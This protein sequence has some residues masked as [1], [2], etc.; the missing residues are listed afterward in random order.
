MH[1]KLSQPSTVLDGMNKVEMNKNKYLT[2]ITRRL[3]RA[4]SKQ[5]IKYSGLVVINIYQQWTDK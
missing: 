3:Y 1:K 5:H 4:F 2:V